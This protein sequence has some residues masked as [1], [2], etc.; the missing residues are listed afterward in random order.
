MPQV[1]AETAYL[2]TPT[3]SITNFLPFLD[4][5]PG[6]MPWRTRAESYRKQHD[7]LYEKLVDDAVTG[8]ASGMST[9]AAFFAKEDK[10]EGDQRRL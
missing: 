7:A 2:A 8:K 10:P 3:A 4:L 6:P 5:I 9:W 1:L